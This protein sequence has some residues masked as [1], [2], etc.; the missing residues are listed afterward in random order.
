MQRLMMGLVALLLVKS[1]HATDF[2]ASSAAEAVRFLQG[3]KAGDRVILKDGIYKDVNILFRNTHGTAGQPVVFLPE[4]PGK[5]FF[6]GNST[7]RFSGNDIVVQGFVFRNGGQ[8]LKSRQVIELRTA[9]TA[10][11]QHCTV[12]DCVID[13]YNNTDKTTVNTWVGLYGVY[14]TVTRCLFKG[15]DNRGPTLVVW[16]QEGKPAHHTISYN[17]FLSR[18]NGPGADNGLESMRIGDS[19][20]SFTNANCVVALNR[21]EDCDGEIEVIS[22]KSCHNSLLHNSF[23]NCDGGLTLRHGNNSL[24]DGNFFDGGNKPLSYG[25]RIIGEGHTVINNYFYNLHGASNEM[26]RAPV[27]ILNGLI[28]TPI[29][30]YF[31]V[32]RALVTDNVFVNCT[33]PC[34]RLGAFSKREG[35]KLVPD[36]VTIANNLLF[37]DVGK[38]GKVYEAISEPQHL[39][40]RDNLVIGAYLVANITGFRQEKNAGVKRMDFDSIT[41]ANGQV[42]ADI[43]HKAVATDN[44]GAGADWVPPAIAAA[45]AG[46]KYTHV[47]VQEVGPEWMK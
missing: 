27:T 41:D 25:I 7:L 6:E 29:N 46:R 26:F 28:N 35:M 12:Q 17:Y 5:V 39:M 47:S 38:V 22:N 18:Q 13:A 36:S 4:H 8:D 40:A 19:K 20:T 1:V 23:I 14:N 30:G 24:C 34:I 21:F 45:I 44:K 2:L 37:D 15:K 9:D 11:A 43:H 32:H 42:I 16:L 3:A 33:T 10:E 31:Q